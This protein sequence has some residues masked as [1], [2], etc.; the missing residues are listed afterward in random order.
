MPFESSAQWAKK[1]VNLPTGETV[2][3]RVRV[4]TSFIDPIQQYQ[5]TRYTIDNSSKS[6]RTSH[7]DL[8]QSSGSGG[9][10]QVERVDTWPVIDGVESYQETRIAFDNRTKSDSPPPYFITHLKTHLVT[11]H[12]SGSGTVTVEMIDQFSVI[13][14]VDRNQE[15]IY[16]LSQPQTDDDAQVQ[17][18]DP[19]ITDGAD[20][21]IDPPWRLDPFQNIVDFTGVPATSGGGV[22]YRTTM[23][24]Q[25]NNTTHQCVCFIQEI[26]GQQ[27]IDEF[28]EDGVFQ[29]HI[30]GSYHDLPSL[31]VGIPDDQEYFVTGI[32]SSG[33]DM[34]VDM[35]GSLGGSA[36]ASFNFSGTTFAGQDAWAGRTWS[37]DSS[38][39]SPGP[40]V[41][42]QIC[43]LVLNT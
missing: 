4:E 11:Y 38:V 36:G 3:V 8:V 27:M 28:S 34:S 42:G 25:A 19:D 10:I 40:P 9:E 24:A 26:T 33:G 43:T 13:D 37:I 41:P 23:S 6:G 29:G 17:D 15:T 22:I 18:G 30:F 12:G 5:E 14:P 2:P 7:V 32:T 16:S 21:T 39:A 1:L 20:Q 35:T 31:A